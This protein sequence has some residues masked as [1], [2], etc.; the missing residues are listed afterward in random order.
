MQEL[1]KKKHIGQIKA[2]YSQCFNEGADYEDFYFKKVFSDLGCFGIFDGEKLVSMAFISD[3]TLVFDNIKISCPL[4]LAV[5][6]DKEY[7]R[8]GLAFTLIEKIKNALKNQGFFC[9]YLSPVNPNIYKSN[10]FIPFCFEE[11]F[12]VKYGGGDIALKEASKKDIPLLLGFYQ[13]F[14]STK[15]AYALRTE[16]YYEILLESAVLVKPIQLL[17]KGADCLGYIYFDGF[18]WDICADTNC[19]CQIKTLDG[20]KISIPSKS[21]VSKVSQMICILD[22]EKL[23]KV[24]PH[25]EYSL[26][27]SDNFNFDK[28]Q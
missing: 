12:T 8:K 14:C 21:K 3:K 25:I 10:G 15:N 22:E 28:Y 17:C 1:D 26:K 5:C 9:T 18:Y 23:K 2:L 24:C 20:V 11:N 4:I 13:K 7:R 27:K 16:R 19:L 6:V